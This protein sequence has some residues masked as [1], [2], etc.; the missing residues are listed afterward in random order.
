MAR[1]LSQQLVSDYVQK[2]NITPTEPPAQESIHD[3]LNAQN[4]I[5]NKLVTTAFD[6]KR[7][8]R[9][10]LLN[11]LQEQTGHNLQAKHVRK[12]GTAW[13]SILQPP[14]FGTKD[15]V[16][17]N[18][19]A[20]GIFTCDGPGFEQWIQRINMNARDVTKKRWLTLLGNYASGDLL[21]QITYFQK[22]YERDG[23]IDVPAMMMRINLSLGYELSPQQA[24]DKLRTARI[25]RDED[26]MQLEVRLGR[27]ADAAV[28]DIAGDTK[29]PTRERLAKE[30]FIRAVP[31]HI[32]EKI[33]DRMYLK[34]MNGHDEPSYAQLCSEIHQMTTQGQVPLHSRRIQNVVDED[35]DDDEP[36]P[37]INNVI[38]DNHHDLPNEVV[39][40]FDTSLMI[41]EE[42]GVNNGIISQVVEYMPSD[43]VIYLVRTKRGFGKI[44]AS[45]LNVGR[46]ECLKCGE[47]GHR[48]TG[49]GSHKCK[50]SNQP[51][52]Y[53]CKACKKGGHL[54]SLCHRK[55]S[56]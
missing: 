30:A 7:D 37:R 38:P 32:R 2:S 15:D 48:M 36:A 13:Q 24:R 49:P 40:Q 34:T 21:E 53:L 52:T 25:E 42:P 3:K 54:D 10:A 5:L 55:N 4:A 17:L 33:H 28:A 56:H 11:I 16:T 9:D 22:M 31:A 44:R 8:V 23:D 43:D 41:D 12:D 46:D 39:S 51:L 20:M 18:P 45:T 26:I 19:K 29:T 14:K 27:I 35:D 6:N 47:Q 50:Y 1:R